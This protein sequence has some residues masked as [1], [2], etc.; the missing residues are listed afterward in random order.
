MK[1]HDLLDALYMR[2][3]HARSLEVDVA[4]EHYHDL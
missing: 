4:L 1:R 2:L 3:Q